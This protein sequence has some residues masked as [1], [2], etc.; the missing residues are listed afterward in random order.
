[1]KRTVA[2]LMAFCMLITM[3]SCGNSSA[4]ENSQSEATTS[5]NGV[6]DNVVTGTTGS[7]AE[8][9]TSVDYTETDTTSETEASQEPA[10][11]TTSESS[12]SEATTTTADDED[13]VDLSEEEVTYIPD[14]VAMDYLTLLNSTQVH[15]KLTEAVS[16]DGETVVMYER[17]Y[18]I[19]GVNKVY[20]NNSQKI[21]MTA[22]T[23]TVI[24]LDAY[25]YYSYARTSTA[26]EIEFG[27][28]KEYYTLVSTSEGSDCVIEE[29]T[30]VS[31]GSTIS[32]TWTFYTDGTFTVVDENPDSGSFTKYY[33]DVAESN[34]SGMD[35][36]I[37]D[38]LTETTASEF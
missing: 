26:S 1:M 29:Y 13:S 30:V 7:E 19:S 20:I 11:T 3:C 6:P 2:V 34:V 4:E 37:P 14:T 9:V 33:F 16:Y 24:D 25:T 31:H 35:M 27:Y 22:D 5:Y 21:V 36:T 32:S 18:Y 38:G 28:S 12:S 10:V 17:E 15:A 8:A 23:V